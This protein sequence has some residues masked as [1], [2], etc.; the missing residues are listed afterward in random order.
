MLPGEVNVGELT[1]PRP[2]VLWCSAGNPGA[3][4]FARELQAELAGGETLIRVVTNKPHKRAL[5]SQGE[6][7]VMLLYLNKVPPC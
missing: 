5:D 4:E 7:V 1:L 6:S 3:K 2:L